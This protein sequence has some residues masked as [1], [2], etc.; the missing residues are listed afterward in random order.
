LASATDVD[1]AVASSVGAAAVWR[2]SSLA[3]RQ[4]VLFAAR[5]IVDSRRGELAAAITSEHGKVLTDAADEVQRGLEVLE[6]A[7]G[8]PHLLKGGFSEGVSTGIDVYAIRQPLG[9]VAVISPFNFPGM[10][11][12]WFVLI[13]DRLR[14]CRR[15]Q[16]Q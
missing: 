1:E 7:C 2:T 5:Q 4:K 6:F 3:T 12:L 8:I 14:Q 13:L 15:A 11:P 9:V 10:V 16:A